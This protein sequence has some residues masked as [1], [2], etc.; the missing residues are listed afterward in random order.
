MLYDLYRH[1]YMAHVHKSTTS[2]AQVGG[3]ETVSHQVLP[4]P[5]HEQTLFIPVYAYEVPGKS[6]FA[7]HAGTQLLADD[8]D[9]HVIVNRY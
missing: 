2:R 7:P 5:T 6:I 8:R 9:K 4:T 1:Q 3:V